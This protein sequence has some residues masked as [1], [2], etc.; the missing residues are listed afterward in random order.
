MDFE[1]CMSSVVNDLLP[2]DSAHRFQI[3]GHID[4]SFWAC[5]FDVSEPELR[6]A[7]SLIP[8][9]VYAV[10]RYLAWRPYLNPQMH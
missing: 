8:L 10:Q 2:P 1:F 3:D 9:E 6:Y 5:V 4:E 7:T